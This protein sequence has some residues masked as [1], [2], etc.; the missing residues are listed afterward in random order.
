MCCV[1]VLV[2]CWCCWC[3]SGIVLVRCRVGTRRI[4][5]VIPPFWCIT[6]VPLLLLNIDI[7]FFWFAHQTMSNIMLFLADNS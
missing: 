5:I 7:I 3:G 1:V 6:K 2:V 4:I